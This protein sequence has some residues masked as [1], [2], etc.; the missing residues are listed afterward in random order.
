VERERDVDASVAVY[1]EGGNSLEELSGKNSVRVWQASIQVGGRENILLLIS[2]HKAP[3]LS[4]HP[5]FQPPRPSPQD[6]RNPLP[7]FPRRNLRSY[8]FL[9]FLTYVYT[10]ITLHCLAGVS[11]HTF[12]LGG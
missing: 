11:S 6:L 8:F 9:I 4:P 2:N 3:D 1:I 12:W 10:D 5:T 7:L